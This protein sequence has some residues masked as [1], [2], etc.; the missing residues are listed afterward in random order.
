MDFD[1]SATAGQGG[2]A[3]GCIDFDDPDNKGLQDCTSSSSAHATLN[4]AY[5]K[6]C[7]R[8]SLA[9]FVVLAAGEW[10]IY[11]KEKRLFFWVVGVLFDTGW[12]ITKP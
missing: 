8:V 9:D 4:A 10:C 5:V 7:D 6:F 2:G 11:L 1:P 3:D 12:L